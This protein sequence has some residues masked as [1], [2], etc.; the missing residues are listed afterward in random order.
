MLRRCTLSRHHSRTYICDLRSSPF[1]RFDLLRS[2]HQHGR[3]ED[4]DHLLQENRRHEA[5]WNA[6][7]GYPAQ[8]CTGRNHTYHLHTY[9]YSDPFSYHRNGCSRHRSCL[10]RILEEPSYTRCLH[11]VLHRIPCI[12]HIHLCDASVQSFRYV[13][14]DQ[15]ERRLHP[16][17]QAR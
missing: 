9:C 6:E 8:G 12:L 1:R 2:I 11:S 16:G 4:K 5:V 3:K 7:P 14:T 13:I 17:Y 15:A 10:G